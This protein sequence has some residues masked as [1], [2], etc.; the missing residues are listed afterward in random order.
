VVHIKGIAASTPIQII[1][2]HPL[3]RELKAHESFS[4][5]TVGA[6][7]TFLVEQMRQRGLS[8][9]SLEATLLALGIY[10]DTGS[11]TY[12]TTTARDIQAAA[13]LIEQ[14]G[15]LDIIRRFL[16]QSLSD[17]QQKL[18]ERLI[19]QSES[20]SLEGYTVVVASAVADHY[21]AEI[22]SIAHK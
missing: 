15:E 19:A 1:D 17:D 18:M 12:G 7:T 10:E 16:A 2:H 3:S 4:G 11:L 22:S 21:V 5:E 20:R 13:W 6:V 9:N 8:L 14:G